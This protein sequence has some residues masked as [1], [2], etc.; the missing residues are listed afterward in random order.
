MA[1]PS[2]ES[3]SIAT[4]SIPQR[5]EPPEDLTPYAQKIW[6]DVVS[7]KPPEWFESDSFPLLRN[8]CE[9]AYQA[10]KLIKDINTLDTT[11][12][13]EYAELNRAWIQ[14]TKLIAELA[15]KMR[16]TQQSRYTPDKAATANK[17]AR[18][19]KKPWEA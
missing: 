16:L 2:A 7:T 17:K 11:R 18:G 6:K 19:G 14:T 10:D 1:K 9:A 12:C 3:L 4:V 15:V 13:K 5:P 8:Y